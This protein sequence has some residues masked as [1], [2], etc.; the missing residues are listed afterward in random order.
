[1]SHWPASAPHALITKSR[2]GSDPQ[3]SK[4]AASLYEEGPNTE[5]SIVPLLSGYRDKDTLAITFTN[6]YQDLRAI[7]SEHLG[8]IIPQSEIS[9]ASFFSID[10]H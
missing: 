4:P 8:I 10:V 7:H 3:R 1:M 2:L 9:H 5:I 6:D